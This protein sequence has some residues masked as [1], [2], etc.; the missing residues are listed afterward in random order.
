M[1][2]AFD[3]PLLE[4]GRYIHYKGN[5][6]EVLGVGRHTEKEE[7][8]VVYRVVIEKAGAPKIWLRPYDMFIETVEVDGKKIP[9]FKKV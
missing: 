5:E 4:P 3:I 9:R 6:Y 8:F 7:Y 1:S 2:E